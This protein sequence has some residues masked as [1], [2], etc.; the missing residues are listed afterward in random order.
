M[1]KDLSGKRALVTGAASGIGRSTI[2]ALAEAGACVVGL[3]RVRPSASPH[4]FVIADLTEEGEIVRAVEEAIAHLGGLDILIN[5]AGIMREGG[6]RAVTAKDIDALLAVNLRGAIL[7]TREALKGMGEGGRIVN[8]ASELAYLGRQNASVYV[9]TKCAI[10]GLTRSWARE[11]APSILVNAVAPGPTD[12][13]LLAF[14]AMTP[15]EK[16]LELANPLGRIGRPEEIA[17]AIVYLAAPA[18][19][20]ASTAGRRWREAAIGA[21][22]VERMVPVPA[23]MPAYCRAGRRRRRG[24]AAPGSVWPLAVGFILIKP[25]HT[26]ENQSAPSHTPGNCRA[27]PAS[28]RATAEGVRS[29]RASGTL[30]S[31]TT[32]AGPAVRKIRRSASSTASRALWVTMSAVMRRSCHSS[33]SSRRSR[34]AVS[35]SSETNGSSSSRRSGSTAKARAKAT[36]RAWPSDNSPG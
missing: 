25:L 35:A 17:A 36:L 22:V 6:V 2:D 26:T 24:R 1:V 10:I 8:V 21:E 29:L 9:A 5:N 19:A 32:R 20:L 4:R 28:T 13:P 34:L 15:E 23:R 7:V 16:A 27:M 12:T 33:A 18:T 3:D 14:E 30:N 31:P 11:L